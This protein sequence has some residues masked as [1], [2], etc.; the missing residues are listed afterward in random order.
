MTG[1]AAAPDRADG[2]RT[3]RFAPVEFGYGPL[4]KALHIARAVRGL[5]GDAVRLELVAS[6]NFLSPVDAR[7]FDRRMSD[8]SEAARAD[9]VVTVMNIKGIKK[10]SDRRE[11]IYVVDS[12][13]WLWDEP[14]PI[15]S[16]I[17]TYFYQDLPVLPV[18][19]RNLVGM[20]NPVPVSA[21][22]RLPGAA[23]EGAGASAETGAPA[24]DRRLVISLSGVET[25]S[26]QLK[27]GN[28]WYPPYILESLQHLVDSGELDVGRLS[29]FG[30]STVLRH[31][32]RGG[33]EVA[34]RGGSQDEFGLA[35]REAGAVVCPPGLTTIVECL[36]SGVGVK[37]LPPQN[38]SQVKLMKAFVRCAGLPAM[39]WTGAVEEWLQETTLPENIGAAIVQGMVASER[40]A[41]G[42][43]APSTLLALLEQEGPVIGASE[44]DKLIGADDGALTVARRILSD[45]PA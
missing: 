33:I 1:A 12:L 26:A 19:E 32:A 17:H 15:Q 16:R 23:S 31:F 4:G 22:G 44:V 38:F 21:I 20:P 45:L 9:A 30:N 13:A 41:N 8:F 29:L 35:A 3:I 18:P 40:L 27:Q 39:P 37:L 34:V 28:V 36:R 14:L 24:P 2:R 6:D 5:V 25:P 10:A 7:L 11:K 43:A 42:C